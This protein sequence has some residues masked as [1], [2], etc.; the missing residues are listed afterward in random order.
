MKKY[1]LGVCI[2]IASHQAFAQVDSIAS[3]AQMV[4]TKKGTDTL[5]RNTIA[6]GINFSNVGLNNWAGGGQNAMSF[7]GVVVGTVAYHKDRVHW[8]NFLDLAYGFQRLGNK[9]AP[10]RKSDDRIYF[11]TKFAYE[12]TKKL[13]YAALADFRSQFAQ[14]FNYYDNVKKDSSV[15]ISDFLAPAYIKASI[16]LEYLPFKSTSIIFSPVAAK[17]TIVNDQ[18]LSDSGAYGVKRGQTLRKEYG[19]S[20][21]LKYKA[22][23]FKNVTFATQLYLFDNYNNFNVDVFWDCFL[24]LKVN[25]FLTTTF[26]TSL[27]YDDDINITRDNGSVGPAVQFKNV[28]AVGL[29]Y[30]LNGY[31]IK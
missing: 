21:M 2:L 29:V 5:W 25:K 15:K 17:Y 22:D 19:V 28:L 20:F 12:Q 23:I 7:V 26:T 13:R 8:N 6:F 30:K 16:G 27:I 11:Q 14:G 10:F 9:S 31:G 3:A 18:A 1:L 24:Y 4:K